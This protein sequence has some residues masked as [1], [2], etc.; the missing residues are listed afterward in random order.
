MKHN[1]RC[2]E[3]H[4]Q[5]DD[6]GANQ[7]KQDK[8]KERTNGRHRYLGKLVYLGDHQNRGESVRPADDG[9][10]GGDHDVQPD[11]DKTNENEFCSV[12]PKPVEEIPKL[13]TRAILLPFQSQHQPAQEHRIQDPDRQDCYQGPDDKNAEPLK[14]ILAKGA[15][16]VR[17]PAHP[18]TR[19]N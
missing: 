7:R 6:Q 3:P 16:S 17:E 10:D 2:G 18:P 19:P 12:F 4:W 1:E 15:K 8:Q 13:Q 11:R 5:R 9:R 14:W